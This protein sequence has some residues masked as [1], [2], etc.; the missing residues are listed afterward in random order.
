GESVPAKQAALVDGSSVVAYKN[1]S[2]LLT[3]DVGGHVH[4]VLSLAS[5]TNG[6]ETIQMKGR[7]C[8]IRIPLHDVHVAGITRIPGSIELIEA[9]GTKSSER[10]RSTKAVQVDAYLIGDRKGARVESDKAYLPRGR[11]AVRASFERWTGDI[12]TIKVADRLPQ[13]LRSLA[14][15]I[16]RGM[17][18]WSGTFR[19][20]R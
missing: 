15:R 5:V 11:Y 7:A 13:R 19:R 8:S 6:D 4:H 14:G 17:S 2:D 12:G 3:L 18:R 10:A 16:Y 20:S 9:T 1:A